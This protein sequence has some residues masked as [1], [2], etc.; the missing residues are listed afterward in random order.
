M[1]SFDDVLA[2]FSD[3]DSLEEA[4]LDES[5]AFLD[6]LILAVLIDGEITEEEL[7]GLDTELAKL[8]FAHDDAMQKEVGDHGVESR[9]RIEEILHDD[10][11]IASFLEELAEDLTREDHREIAI[12]MTAAVAFSDGIVREE[13]ALCHQLGDAFGFDSDEVDQ[14]IDEV[15]EVMEEE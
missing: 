14:I 5:K 4:T 13:A 7:E 15:I 11:A 2:Y 3:E 9:A 10:E 12:G 6:L 8:P 1:S